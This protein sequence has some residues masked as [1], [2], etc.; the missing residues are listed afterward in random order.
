LIKGYEDEIK[1]YK[2]LQDVIDKKYPNISYIICFIIPDQPVTQYYKH[3]DNRTFLFT[4]NDNPDDTS[5]K[6][7]YTPIFHF[8]MNENLFTNIPL[9][10][11]INIKPMSSRLWLVEGYS[12]VNFIEKNY[13][14]LTNT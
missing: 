6:N 2:K 3:L 5:I 12:A 9:S 10:N 7:D 1:H 11:E 4:L 14:S 8:I 13:N